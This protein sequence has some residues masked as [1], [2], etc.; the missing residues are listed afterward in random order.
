MGQDKLSLFAPSNCNGSSGLSVRCCKMTILS[1]WAKLQGFLH[2]ATF[3]NNN[4]NKTIPQ[5]FCL[6]GT[7]TNSKQESSIFPPLGS[8]ICMKCI[9]AERLASSFKHTP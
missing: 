9:L 8:S 5:T 1:M 3:K 4:N 6:G 7:V 2:W